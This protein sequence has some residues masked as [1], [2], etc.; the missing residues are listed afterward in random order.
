[1]SAP[2]LVT[3]PPPENT[4]PAGVRR[5]LVLNLGV[6]L[7]APL[8]LFYGLR[9]LG[10]D[11]WWA[12]LLS[13]L[14]PVVRA[15]YTVATSRKIDT[16]A[17][18]TLSILALG[19]G[20]SF[21][22][23][24]P[25]FLLAKDGWMTAVAGTWMLATLARTPFILQVMRTLL[26]GDAVERT[27][28]KWQGSP[29]YRRVL[30]TITTMWGV[31]LVLDAGVRVLLAYTLPIDQVPLISGLQYAGLYLVLEVSTR[32]IARRKSIAAAVEAESGQRLM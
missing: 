31:A 10:V 7:V 16:L 28:L 12:V 6:N 2:T 24:S 17:L 26:P 13:A 5:Q 1:M 11:Q 9:A 29:T 18:F 15:C 20:T 3:P 4:R 23:G 19:V 22:S 25:R 27:E 30:R 32:L 21:L 14:P 8:A